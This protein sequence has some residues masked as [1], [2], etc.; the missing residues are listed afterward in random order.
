MDVRGCIMSGTKRGLLTSAGTNLQPNRCFGT[1]RAVKA[2]GFSSDDNGHRDQNTPRRLPQHHGPIFDGPGMAGVW[3]SDCP[4]DNS[5]GASGET[6]LQID[7]AED[8][9]AA[10]EWIEVDP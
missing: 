8:R 10:F 5:E 3:V 7:I 6:L 1:N 2:D 9:L 4:L